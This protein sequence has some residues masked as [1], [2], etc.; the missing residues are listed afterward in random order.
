MTNPTTPAEVNVSIAEPKRSAFML[1]RTG[2]EIMPGDTLKVFHFTGPRHKRYFMFK[3]VESLEARASWVGKDA[4]VISHL[5]TAKE[6]YLKIR[7]NSVWEDCEIVQGYGNDGLCF[8]ER[9]KLLSV[10]QPTK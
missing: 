1:D 5:N 8:D 3:Y 7:D 10:K 2:R 9:P 4:L 6:T